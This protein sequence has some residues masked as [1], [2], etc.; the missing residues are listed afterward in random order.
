MFED[1][2]KRV[3]KPSRNASSAANGDSA[4]A[5]QKQGR[6]QRL[7]NRQSTEKSGRSRRG[8]YS[9]DDGRDAA[10]AASAPGPPTL[11]YDPRFQSSLK[12]GLPKTP[13]PAFASTS[14]D[15]YGRDAVG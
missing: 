12:A 14:S 8:E 13:T 9:D 5:A 11:E 6:G 2:E 3:D 7:A 4:R 10:P 15:V 1:R